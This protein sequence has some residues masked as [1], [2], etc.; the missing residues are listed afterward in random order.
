MIISIY[1]NKCVHCLGNPPFGK[2][3]SLARKFIK[4]LS[5]FCDSISFIL[6][7]SFRKN[8]YKNTFPLNFHLVKE[9]DIDTNAFTINGKEH[10]V[11]CIFQIWIKK[12]INREI[13]E[14]L[15]E[16]GFKFVK[17][18]QTKKIND[19][20]LNIF[21]EMPDFGILRAGGGNKC[22]RISLNYMNG[23]LCYSQGWLFIK[24]DNKYNKDIFYDSY[25]KID[26]RDDSNVAAKS[27]NKQ[28]FIKNI[29]KL[30]K[31]M[32]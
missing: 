6:P 32:D 5:I 14:K 7:K 19:S 20:I 8:S 23:K 24:L 26:W 2:Q 12:T 9:I 13:E 15:T 28:T 29:N 22:G 4:K 21:T 18:P 27:I 31:T 25:K 11:P 10:N 3:S 1:K 30:L 17:K 16:Y